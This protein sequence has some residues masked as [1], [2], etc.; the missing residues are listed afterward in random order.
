MPPNLFDL[1]R[2]LALQAGPQVQQVT[3]PREGQ[4]VP[5]APPAV[6]APQFPLPVQLQPGLNFGGGGPAPRQSSQTAPLSFSLEEPE[7][8]S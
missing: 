7:S 3:S 1:K 6:Q 5:I 2:Q 8:F 4:R